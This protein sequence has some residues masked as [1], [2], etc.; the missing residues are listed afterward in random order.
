MW[1]SMEACDVSGEVDAAVAAGSTACG[2]AHV[3]APP[4]V[5]LSLTCHWLLLPVTGREAGEG[6]EIRE[7]QGGREQGVRRGWMD[8]WMDEWTSSSAAPLEQCVSS[9]H[10]AP[11][12]T[13]GNAGPALI[14]L[15]SG[16]RAMQAKYG[17]CNQRARV[18]PAAPA[19]PAVLW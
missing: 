11:I 8:G 17:L 7:Q 1:D 18:R 4:W 13:K 9:T 6:Q 10:N 15:P 12:R 3:Y 5:Q 2:Q 16:P 19:V 14:M